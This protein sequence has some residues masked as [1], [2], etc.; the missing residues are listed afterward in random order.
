MEWGG[1]WVVCVFIVPDCTCLFTS[2]L[3]ITKH[4]S[5]RHLWPFPL[6]RRCVVILITHD[7]LTRT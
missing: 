7:S 1:G 6:L 5:R 3:R 4:H 2:P